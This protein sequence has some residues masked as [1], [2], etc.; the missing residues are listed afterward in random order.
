MGARMQRF[1]EYV[2]LIAEQLGHADRVGPFR[3]YCTG[4]L[5]PVKRKSVEPMAAHLAPANVR[6]DQAKWA[7]VVKASGARPDWSTKTCHNDHQ[8]NAPNPRHLGCRNARHIR[9]DSS[10]AKLMNRGLARQL[11]SIPVTPTDPAR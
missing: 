7:K 4:L 3:G 11:M 8:I 5:L 10:T 1:E 6:A 9:L 2:S